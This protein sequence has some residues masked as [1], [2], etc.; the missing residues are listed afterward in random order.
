MAHRGQAGCLTLRLLQCKLSPRMTGLPLPTDRATPLGGSPHLSCQHDQDKLR[1][2]RDSPVLTRFWPGFP[3]PPFPFPLP[4]N[5][6]VTSPTWGLPRT[7]KCKWAINF[8]IFETIA[9]CQ[10][11]NKPYARQEDNRYILLDVSWLITQ[12]V[13]FPCINIT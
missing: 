6:Q 5:T 12:S 2:Y 7:C 13:R 3:P 9:W 4:P 1:D 11:H 10:F 8:V